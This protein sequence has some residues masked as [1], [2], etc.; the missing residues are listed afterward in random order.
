MRRMIF[1]LMAIAA[2]TAGA[3]QEFYVD[4]NIGDDDLY[5]GSAAAIGENGVGP[6]KTLQAAA[7][8]VTATTKG[9]QVGDTIHI[10]EGRY[11]EGT[12][13]NAAE[14]AVYRAYLKS[15]TRLVGSG[16]KERTFIVG[17]PS[18]DASADANECGPGAVKGLRFG[19]W[20]LVKGV[21]I[22]G[23]RAPAKTGEWKTEPVA[24]V[25]GFG[26]S[27]S[28]LVDCI[29]SNTWSTA[30]QSIYGGGAIRCFVANYRGD[31]TG[32]FARYCGT[33]AN[34]VIDG[35]GDTTYALYSL[36]ALNCSF[37]GS[38][39][40]GI[41][42]RPNRTPRAFAAAMPSACRWRINSRS[43]WAT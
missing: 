1:G 9:S 2:A 24:G 34:C 38:S 30:G 5:D 37:V 15:G 39:G 43:V 10:A 18:T 7:A 33:F 19:E 36:A 23:C 8:L 16:A 12:W 42:F 31:A 4:A 22:C 20:V 29:I 21:T 41:R 25:A 28:F 27:T 11:D 40:T 14:T 13:T 17:A 35:T 26:S 6:K 3:A 32:R